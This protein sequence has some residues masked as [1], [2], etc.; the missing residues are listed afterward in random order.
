[1]MTTFRLCVKK[2]GDERPRSQLET[3]RF[4]LHSR[5]ERLD[6]LSRFGMKWFYFELPD[7]SI[8]FPMANFKLD[9]FARFGRFRHGPK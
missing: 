1:M 5:N 4:I 7:L 2:Y 3:A 8:V 6:L 9:A